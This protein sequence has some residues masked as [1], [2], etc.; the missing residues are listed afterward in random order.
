MMAELGLS[1]AEFGVLGGAFFWLFAVAA[2]A[3]GWLGDRTSPRFLIGALASVWALAQLLVSGAG[4]FASVLAG[5]LLL[6][7]GEGPAYPSALSFLFERIP[8]RDWVTHGGIV[9]AGGSVGAGAGTVALAA[10]IARLGWRHA[11]AVLALLGVAWSIVWLFATR[12]DRLPRHAAPAVDTSPIAM[13]VA[14][15][16]LAA[17]AFYSVTSLASVWFPSY[18]RAAGMTTAQSALVISAAWLCQAAALPVFGPLSDVL[19]R[20][21]LTP[22]AS[23]L[24][25]ASAG[26]L[27]SGVALFVLAEVTVPALIVAATIGAVMCSASVLAIGPALVAGVVPAT[28]RRFALGSVVGFGSLGGAFAP[29]AF[30][31]LLD[32][33][34]LGRYQLALTAAG[35]MVVALA[36]VAYLCGAPFRVRSPVRSS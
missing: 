31:L 17:V 11:F 16:A 15:V 32:A 23:R 5:R 30:G 6:G 28:R 13:S 2:V 18:L 20:R 27:L 36:V 10:L 35:G 4:A 1:R 22:E 19:E 33:G 12:R 14:S 24:T 7:F 25:L 21:G 3:L 29:S 9:S 8:R 26:L 34:T